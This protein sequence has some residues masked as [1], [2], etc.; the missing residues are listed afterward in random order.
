[1]SELNFLNGSLLRLASCACALSLLGACSLI[2]TYERPAAPVPTQ[3]PGATEAAPGQRQAAD[4]PWQ[5]FFKDARLQRLQVERAAEAS[6]AKDS[7]RLAAQQAR[8]VAQRQQLSQR[9]TTAIRAQQAA[10]AA[11]QR[12]DAAVAAEAAKQQA[13]Q[14]AAAARAKGYTGDCC[15]TCGGTRMVRAGVCLKCEDCGDTSGGCS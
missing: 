9:Y 2:P 10:A 7:Q 4:I 11:Q 5:D 6:A 15:V 1:M 8:D 3:Y 12:K 13:T 14:T